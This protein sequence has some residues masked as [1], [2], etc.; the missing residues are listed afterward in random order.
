MVLQSRNN[1][2]TGQWYALPLLWL[3]VA[4]SFIVFIEPAPYDVI[5]ICLFVLF[6]SIGLKVPTNIRTG[7]VLLGLFILA[8]IVASITAHDPIITLRSLAVRCYMV[9]SWFLFVCLIYENPKA[10]LDTIW[11][12]YSVAA[13][14]CVLVAVAGFYEM[15]PFSEQLIEFGR[16]R[17]LF[18]DPNLYGPFLVPVALCA[19]AKMETANGY[20]MVLHA[21]LFIFIS[22]GVL[23]G[24]SRG[25]WINYALSAILFTGFRF[26]TSQS[27]AQIRRL[28]VILGLVLFLAVAFIIIAAS[29]D[30]VREMLEIR[31][32][33]QNYDVM[34]GGRLSN[35]QLILSEALV[36]PLGVGPYL[37][38][39][40]FYRAPHNI[41]LHVLIESG[42]IGALAFYSFIVV[43]IQKAYKFCLQPTSIQS[44]Y[45]VTLVCTIGILVQSFFIDSTHWRHMYLL[46][47]MLWGP[48]LFWQDEVK[49]AYRLKKQHTAESE[50]NISVTSLANRQSA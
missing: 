19:F 3:Q 8:N 35:Q 18:K 29:T 28:L 15:T 4:T 50:T 26:A 38:E 23:L 31:F 5:G 27:A 42:W 25:S 45:A 10:V 1:L 9:I 30:K 49:T 12:G 2:I 20:R 47:A 7:V 36:H 48:A 41:Y 32:Q 17:A 46:F 44:N 16:V 37:S 39:S 34:Q 33:V 40:L 11:K 13:V 6:F 21:G 24:F 14:L 22:Y 43:T